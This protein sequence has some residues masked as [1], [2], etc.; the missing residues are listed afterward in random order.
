LPAA[1]LE[2]F[3]EAV[4]AIFLG[5]NRRISNGCSQHHGLSGA[6]SCRK[7]VLLQV[8]GRK[9]T[10]EGMLR[11]HCGEAP[12]GERHLQSQAMLSQ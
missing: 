5:L 1:D 7:D 6:K 2:R 11:K 9:K 10:F 12:A 4:S 8:I 3:L